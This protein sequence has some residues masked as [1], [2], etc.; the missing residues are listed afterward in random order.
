MSVIIIGVGNPVLTDDSVGIQVVRRLAE[1]LIGRAGIT[2]RELYAGG[3]SLM[4]AMSGHQKAIIIDAILT[5]G[6]RPGTIYSLTPSDLLHSRNIHSTHD[7]SL[8]VALE[9]GKM[10]GLPLPEEVGIWAVEA[11]DVETFSESL[12]EE[13]ETAVPAVVSQ[14][15]RQLKEVRFYPGDQA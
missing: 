12:T 6:G 5:E 1:E 14:V 13:V 3:I 4:E 7:A 8:P 2:T 9:L 10:T 11:Q 15:L